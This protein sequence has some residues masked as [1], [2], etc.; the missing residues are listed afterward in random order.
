MAHVKSK[1]E[2][3]R[4]SKDDFLLS[5]AMDSKADYLITGD[6]DLLDL[7]TIGKTK[8]YYHS[9]LLRQIKVGK[10]ANVNLSLAR[11]RFQNVMLCNDMHGM[12]VIS[13]Q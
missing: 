1:I 10:H 2:L 11:N 8:I 4:D 5:L 12:Q 9:R 6:N 3:C 7:K 13:H